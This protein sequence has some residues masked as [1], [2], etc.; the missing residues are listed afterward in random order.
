[1]SIALACALPHPPTYVTL[2]G[3]RYA[4]FADIHND[5][6]TLSTLTGA[7]IPLLLHGHTHRQ[8]VWCFTGDNQLQRLS[9]PTI[10]LRS[11][12]IL[13][14]GTGSVGRPVDGPGAAYVIY[15]ETAG[16]IEIIR[17]T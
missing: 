14:V 3:M 17:V 12:D 4:I 6:T 1:M 15:D 5:A 10:Q 2:A 13:V 8:T 16:L 9:Q 11:G 7:N